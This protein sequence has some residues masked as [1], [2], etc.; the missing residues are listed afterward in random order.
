LANAGGV[1]A[2]DESSLSASDHIAVDTSRPNIAR[3]YD[4][5]LGGKDN[6]LA[7]VERKREATA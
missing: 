6:I 4:Y 5:W 3:V 2:A 7:G 1:N